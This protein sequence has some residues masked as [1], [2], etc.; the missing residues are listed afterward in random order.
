MP[1]LGRIGDPD[2]ILASVLVEDGKV[3]RSSRINEPSSQCPKRLGSKHLG[4]PASKEEWESIMRF[5]SEKL[6]HRKV[7]GIYEIMYF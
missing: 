1:A 2:D 6:G 3:P 5:W 7:S 4:M